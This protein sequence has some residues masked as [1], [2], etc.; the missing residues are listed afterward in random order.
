MDYPLEYLGPERF[1]QFCQSLLVR[2]HKDVQCFPVGQPDGGRDAISY[3]TDHSST[4][5]LMSRLSMLADLTPKLI[6]TSGY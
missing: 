4:K 1:Q 5:F 6:P 3:F 2:E